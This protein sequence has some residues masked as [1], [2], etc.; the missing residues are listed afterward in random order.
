MT[1]TAR[2]SSIK[3]IIKDRSESRNNR[4]NSLRKGGAGHHNWGSMADEA[5]FEDEVYEEDL[6]E[7]E[8][9]EKPSKPEAKRRASDEDVADAKQF[10]KHTFDKD[11]DLSAIARTSSAVSVSPDSVSSS[12]IASTTASAV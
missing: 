12:P 8:S 5:R 11:V 7:L 3:A 10:R 9:T 2:S 6:N 4:D 1:R